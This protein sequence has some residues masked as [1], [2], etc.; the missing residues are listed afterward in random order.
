MSSIAISLIGGFCMFGG[1]LF[2]MWLQNRLPKHHLDKESHETVKLGIGIIG[3]LS[4][5]VLGLLVSSAKGTFDTLNSGIV[6]TSADAILLDRV[7]SHYGPDAQ[8]VRESLQATLATAIKRLWP[9]QATDDSAIKSIESARGLEGV[10]GQL[11]Q[12][13]PKDDLQRKLLAIAD[14]VA[15]E[16]MQNRW[17]LIEEAQ[18]QLPAPLLIVLV[19]WL[20]LIFIS[21]G[22]FAPRHATVVAVMLGCALSMAAAIFLIQELNRPLDGLIKVSSAPMRDA[23]AQI[24]Q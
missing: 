8:P 24:G 1:A 2:G 15:G 3:S 17:L 7:L 11:L 16:M 22:L 19:F 13:T 18:N 10:Q 4:A 6:K 21:F 5:L 14:Q 20:T 12:L 9:E 23:L